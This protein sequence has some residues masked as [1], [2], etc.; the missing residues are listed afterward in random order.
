MSL[1]RELLINDPN[2]KAKQRRSLILLRQRVSDKQ[3]E[4]KMQKILV[5]EDEVELAEYLTQ[6]LT[7]N[8]YN[9]KSIHEG[10]PAINTILEFQP[11]LVILDQCLPDTHGQEVLNKIRANSSTKNV[12]VVILTAL[13]QEET[14]MSAFDNGADDYIEKPFSL[15]ILL[16]RIKAILSRGLQKDTEFGLLVKN[17]FKIDCNAYKVQVGEES[18]ET[19]LMEFNI[20][21][22]LFKADGKTLT[23][24]DLITR[25]NAGANVTQRTID[26][27]VCSIRKKLNALGRNIET[28]RGVGYRL[29]I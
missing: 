24:E 7:E 22:E 11:H 10:G 15:S 27:H 4:Y 17:D 8:G 19:T 23:R 12:P 9:A 3:K 20:L 2:K 29:A 14:I 6:S 13:S 21:R 28:I 25:I 26:V 5:V 16:C 18:L 1:C